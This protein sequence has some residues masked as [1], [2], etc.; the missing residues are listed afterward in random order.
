LVVMKEGGRVKVLF[1]LEQTQCSTSVSH[2]YFLFCGYVSYRKLH[3][4]SLPCFKRYSQFVIV[5]EM[6]KT[7]LYVSYLYN[8]TTANASFIQAS[9]N[10]VCFRIFLNIPVLSC[11]LT[12]Y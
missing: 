5:S 9:G 3:L 12:M 1:R 8:A 11:K 2:E 6:R 4:C 10:E 7:T